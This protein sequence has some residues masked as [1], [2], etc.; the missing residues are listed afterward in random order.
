MHVSRVSLLDTQ[1]K[2]LCDSL[3]VRIW[4]RLFYGLTHMR[5]FGYW[6]SDGVRALFSYP[7]NFM[8]SDV[9]AAGMTWEEI[10]VKY[11]R[12]AHH[13]LGVEA[14]EEDIRDHMYKQI[15]CKSCATNE[16]VDNSVYVSD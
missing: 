2:T 14:S 7:G 10:Q 3:P 5:T 12:A 11:R 16:E 1:I 4:A 6:N 8:V 15:L 13:E 9:L